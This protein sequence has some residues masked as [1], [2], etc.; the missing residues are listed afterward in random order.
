MRRI[1]LTLSFVSWSG[2]ILSSDVDNFDFQ[3]PEKVFEFHA[4]DLG[5]STATTLDCSTRADVCGQVA[6]G[7]T[8]D[9][10]Q[11]VCV[12]AEDAAFP[13][14]DCSSQ[15]VC[16][17]FGPGVQCLQ[18]VCEVRYDVA[19]TAEVNLAQEV[20]EL[21]EVGSSRLT[22]VTL[23]SLYTDVQTNTLGVDLPALTIYVADVGVTDFE[24]DDSGN[25]VTPG[26]VE[27]GTL[28]SI[29]ANQ[30]GHYDVQLTE[31]GKEELRTRLETPDVPFQFV[32]TGHIELGPGD[33]LP[34]LEDGAIRL[35]VSGTASAGLAGM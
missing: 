32:V 12:L 22:D 7:L 8:C 33:P 21:K 16:G 3:L 31:S 6:E 30:A 27:V 28:P 35:V 2:C 11:G 17:D 20:P 26:V 9:K 23:G 24:F 19:L 10:A 4:E 25:L 14:V 15:D 34:N 29:P 5:L 18:G 1:L 13:T